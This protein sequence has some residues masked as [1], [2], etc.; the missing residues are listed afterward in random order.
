MPYHSFELCHISAKETKN[1]S[2]VKG[3]GAIERNIITRRCKKILLRLLDDQAK[4]SRLKTVNFEAV[5]HPVAAN[6]ASTTRRVSGEYGILRSRVMT[7]ILQNYWFI[8]LKSQNFWFTLLKRQKK[9][10]YNQSLIF[11][12]KAIWKK[13]VNDKKHN[14]LVDFVILIGHPIQAERSYNKQNKTRRISRFEDCSSRRW[15]KLKGSEKL[16]K[17]YNLA[18]ELKLNAKYNQSFWNNPE[19][20]RKEIEDTGG[21]EKDRG[22]PD[23]IPCAINSNT[24]KILW[25]LRRFAVT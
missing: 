21:P 23:H 25:K 6:P 5:L 20:P 16:D 14:I 7:K 24:E 4:S 22:R 3:E 13:L 2:C 8:L 18:R 1:I 10:D 17:Y 12:Q 15:G 9:N 19:E 11:Y